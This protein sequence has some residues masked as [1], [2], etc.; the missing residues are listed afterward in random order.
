MVRKRERRVRYAVVGLGHIAQTAVL[1]AFARARSH[2]ELAALVSGDPGKLRRLAR[3]YRAAA[4]CSYEEFPALLESGGIDAVYLALPNH[5]HRD[6]GV[7]AARAGVHVLCE[8]PLAVAEG[9]C[10][11]M[12]RAAED[13]DVRLMTAYRL[14][15]EGGNREALRVAR[16]G[17]I[18]E[19]RLFESAFTM[20]VSEGNVR[21]LPEEKG[22][23]PLYDIGVYCINAARHLFGAEP[24]EVTARRSSSGERRFRDV[25]DSVGAVLRFPEDRLAV[26]ACSFDAAPSGWYRLIGTKG[27]LWLDP[28]FDIAGALRLEVSSGGRSRA[29]TF[30]RRDQFAA[31]IAA[32]SG[33]VF[34]GREP[35]PSGREGLADVRVIRAL[36]RSAD[37]GRPETLP[38]FDRS[39]RPKPTLVRF[40]PPSVA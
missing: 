9:E 2:S 4:T 15:F 5:L 14:H 23:G 17:R 10:E 7:A 29:R 28:A 39:E 33:A 32:F 36:L 26:F 25:A 30:S 34:S 18:G 37:A 1:P 6:F 38:A 22:G 31:E 19:L 13:A 12:I 3:R 8:K 35:E 20:Q 11:D 27:E 16:S 40:S 21:L 24:V